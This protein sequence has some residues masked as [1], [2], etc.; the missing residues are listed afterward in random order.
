MGLPVKNF[1]ETT[2]GEWEAERV[3]GFKVGDVEV[4]PIWEGGEKD[5]DTI[6]IN[7]L[8]VFGSGSHPTTRG[9]LEAIWELRGKPIKSILDLG[10]GTGILSLFSL[11]VF[12][13]S[14]AFSVDKNPL[15][16]RCALENARL[17]GFE[18]RMVVVCGDALDAV[19]R[20]S[21]D[22]LVANIPYEVIL[23]LLEE[24]N[25]YRGRFYILS[26]FMEGGGKRVAE[27]AE[28]R[29]LSLIS[30]RRADSWL[31]LT[32]SLA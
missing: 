28:E 4:R 16:V 12:P 29:G 15:C 13:N 14:R 32:F 5:D 18:D 8:V 2:Y 24:K 21:F 26:G 11:K 19:K 9:C 23:S 31:V 6:V 10:T 7:P 17:N 25:F 20:F 1:Y 3:T 30:S 22:L 27:E